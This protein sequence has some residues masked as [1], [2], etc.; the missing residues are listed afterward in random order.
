MK[1]N[2]VKENITT[3]VFQNRRSFFKLLGLSTLFMTAP[4][5]M[6]ARTLKT[7]NAGDQFIKPADEMPDNLTIDGQLVWLCEPR[8][9]G[10]EYGGLPLKTFYAD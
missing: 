7:V 3:M 4:K 9:A 1:F 5:Q 10:A 6:F 8:D 2:P